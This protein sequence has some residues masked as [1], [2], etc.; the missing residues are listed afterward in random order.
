MQR[1][2]SSEKA[3]STAFSHKEPTKIPHIS[4]LACGSEKAL[5][6][7]PKL[8]GSQLRGVGS[9]EGSQGLDGGR[10]VEGG[11]ESRVEG[12]SQVEG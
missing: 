6:L 3:R 10:R 4:G 11:W 5:P 9:G 1:D 8:L 2:A 12:G 7:R